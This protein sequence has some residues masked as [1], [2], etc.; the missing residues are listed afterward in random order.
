MTPE[1]EALL[2][3]PLP[4]LILWRTATGGVLK[5]VFN[6]GP[7]APA[8]TAAYEKR[9][10]RPWIPPGV[11]GWKAGALEEWLPVRLL[12]ACWRLTGPNG[13]A[14]CYVVTEEDGGEES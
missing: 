2:A 5:S 7:D 8:L 3:G 1:V 9:L 4:G 12:P 13:V 10:C 14:A 11:V 6:R